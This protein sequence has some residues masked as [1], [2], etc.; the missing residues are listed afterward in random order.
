[1]GDG[2]RLGSGGGQGGFGAVDFGGADDEQHEQGDGHGEAGEPEGLHVAARGESHA[3]G[4]TRLGV[5]CV[6]CGCSSNAAARS[7][8]SQRGRRVTRWAPDV[9]GR[10]LCRSS[11]E[12]TRIAI[13]LTPR[14]ATAGARRAFHGTFTTDC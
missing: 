11:E 12:I 8:R 14:R 1:M 6:T 2:V 4:V 5:D 3:G 13:L 7:P 10:R 9:C